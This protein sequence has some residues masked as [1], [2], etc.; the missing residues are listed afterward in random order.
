MQAEIAENDDPHRTPMARV[1]CPHC[2]EA[3]NYGLPVA[4]GRF[5]VGCI[6]CGQV[7][8]I[9]LPQEAYERA[10]WARVVA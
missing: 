3:G 1:T 2:N 5:T 10:G 8:N 7:F 4:P 9:G 6:K